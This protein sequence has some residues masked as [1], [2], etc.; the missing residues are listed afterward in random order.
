MT[1]ADSERDSG[2]AIIH[3][4]KKAPWAQARGHRGNPDKKNRPHGDRGGEG[5]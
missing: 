3:Q 4:P 5:V 1:S 2:V